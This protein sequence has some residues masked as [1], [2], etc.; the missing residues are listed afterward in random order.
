MRCTTGQK[1]ELIARPFATADT[2][3]SRHDDPFVAK[4][5]QLE[6]TRQVA[7]RTYSARELCPVPISRVA[8]AGMSARSVAGSQIAPKLARD[9]DRLT[10][11][12][13]HFIRPRSSSL[14]SQV[15]PD[16][17]S[18]Q[19]KSDLIDRIDVISDHPDAEKWMSEAEDINPT[20]EDAQ[21]RLEALEREVERAES[22]RDAGSRGALGR[23]PGGRGACRRSPDG[24]G[25]CPR[26]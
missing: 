10:T 11:R 18:A 12:S 26:R 6:S 9:Q 22:M 19:A 4:P 14:S 3:V 17:E 16:M 1:A 24:R 23:S 20:S 2:G 15:V 8:F 25:A 5:L 21:A 7:S 13:G